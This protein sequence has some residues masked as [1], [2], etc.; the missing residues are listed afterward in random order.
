MVYKVL[1]KPAAKKDLDKL[2]D[3][4]VIKIIDR[5]SQLKH[6]PRPIGIQKLTDKE[7]YRIRSG[8]HRILFEI[9]DKLQIIYIYRIKNR[10]DA[11]KK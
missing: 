3:K 7:G 5:I 8:N 6:N 4:E 2:P 11:Y 10:K 9:N 1:I